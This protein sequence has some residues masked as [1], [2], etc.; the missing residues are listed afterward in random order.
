MKQSFQNACHMNLN[1][2]VINGFQNQNKQ[3]PWNTLKT[4]SKEIKLW[5]TLFHHILQKQCFFFGKTVLSW[6]L[7]DWV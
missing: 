5:L 1:K 7:G 4:Q 3:E 6:L 2:A